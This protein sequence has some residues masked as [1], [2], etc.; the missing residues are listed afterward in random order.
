MFRNRLFTW[1]F[2]IANGCVIL[3]LIAL[4]MSQNESGAG[5]FLTFGYDI[6]LGLVVPVQLILAATWACTSKSKGWIRG[7]WLA[8]FVFLASLAAIYFTYKPAKILHEFLI[9]YFAQVLMVCLGFYI[10]K[11]SGLLR[12][13]KADGSEKKRKSQI[14]LKELFGWTT[15][16]A[17]LAAGFGCEIIQDKNLRGLWALMPSL[18]ALTVFTTI[19]LNRQT[20]WL[21]RWVSLLVTAMMVSGITISLSIVLSSGLNFH[22]FWYLAGGYFAVQVYLALGHTALRLGNPQDASEPIDDATR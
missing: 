2:F 11:R 13:S 12:E 8:F 4:A 20:N 21:V 7:A 18:A 6:L 9:F 15:I 3:A 14:S 10:A 16:V 19:L 17:I 5:G 22:N 1:L